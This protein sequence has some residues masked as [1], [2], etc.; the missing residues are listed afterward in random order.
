MTTSHVS[1]VASRVIEKCGGVAAVSK[2]TG[3]APPS[4]HKWRHPK[5]KGGTGGLVPSEVQTILMAAAQRGEV[6]L[7]PVDFFDLTPTQAPGR[8]GAA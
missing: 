6:D 3:R 7:S 8:K 5:E 4:I 1:P 2:I